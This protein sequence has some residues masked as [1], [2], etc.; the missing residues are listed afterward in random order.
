MSLVV[1]FDALLAQRSDDA[2]FV[3]FE[4]YLAVPVL[5]GYAHLSR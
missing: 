3:F 1:D 4:A 2:G 5:V